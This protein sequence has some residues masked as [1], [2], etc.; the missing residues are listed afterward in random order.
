[1]IFI[2]L[3]VILFNFSSCPK[4]SWRDDPVPTVAR[5]WSQ[6]RPQG[7][8]GQS[9]AVGRSFNLSTCLPLR[10]S[11]HSCRPC[12]LRKGIPLRPSTGG[13]HLVHQQQLPRETS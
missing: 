4:S 13:S 9:S 1:V 3:M 5:G 8:M 2:T 11:C 7:R 12:G 6:P 10:P